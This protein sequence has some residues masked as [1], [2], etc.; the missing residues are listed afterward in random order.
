MKSVIKNQDIFQAEYETLQN[1]AAVA[2]QNGL[3]GSPRQACFDEFRAGYKKMLD[4]IVRLVTISD[5]KQEYLFKLQSELKNILDNIGQGILTVDETLT[6]HRRYSA[7]CEAIFG[8]RIDGARFTALIKPYNSAETVNLLESILNREFFAGDE[9]R[10]SV[11]LLLLPG[12][13]AVGERFFSVQ[14][15]PLTFE[16]RDGDENAFM[17]IMA[18]ITEK[19]ALEQRIAAEKSL[20]KAVTKI[21]A[22]MP[23]FAAC[24]REYRDFAATKLP[25]LLD[26]DGA[27]LAASL[28][29]IFREVH[30]LKGN[31]AIFE[32]PWLVDL[33]E[34]VEAFLATCRDRSRTLTWEDLRRG[35][36][37][38]PF[39]T[40]LN[41]SLERLRALIGNRWRFDRDFIMVDLEDFKA[42]EKEARRVSPQL[43]ETLSRMRYQTVA[44]LLATYPEYTVKLAGRL[45]KKI[46]PFTIESEAAVNVDA[47]RYAGFF[48]SLVHVFRNIADHGIELPEERSLVGKAPEGTIQC[49]VT[50]EA[51]GFTIVIRDDGRG[52][53]Y[54][55]V[56]RKAVTLGLIGQEAA[57]DLSCRD[58][59][60][61][62]FQDG[63][64]T[65]ATANGVSGRGVGLAAVKEE[66]EALGGTIA[67]SSRPGEGTQFT[68]YIPLQ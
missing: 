12:E 56:R 43:A 31:F 40:V 38:Y 1:A 34:Q 3:A 4:Q 50:R 21:V 17:I 15:K 36:T 2:R 20:F 52:I 68:F 53:D 32:I 49:L 5:T 27:P 26:P 14:Y 67:V 6:I 13:L 58:L 22:D 41:E 9:L 59:A 57:T 44:H 24:I 65:A 16:A 8:R 33:L 54:E 11:L 30:T 61:L 51:A 60:A 46:T 28:E 23:S 55:A 48:R 37:G 29:T 66:L 19:K 42:V 63:I 39:E 45:G 64:T 35:M 10:R 18:D 25:Q 62:I 7:E 47:D